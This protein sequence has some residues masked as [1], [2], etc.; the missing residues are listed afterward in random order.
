MSPRMPNPSL[1]V[2]DV[3]PPMRALVKAVN[4]VGVPLQTLV[5]IHLRVS[6]I[7]GRTVQLPTK[8]R[9]FEEA[10][11]EDHR[12]PLVEVWREQTCF[13]DAERSVLALAEAATRID[14]RPDP[15]SDEV[16]EEAARHWNQVQLAAVV[17]HIGLVNL[18]NRVNVATR[19][20]PVDWRINPK[21]W[22]PMTS[23]LTP[24]P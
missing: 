5:L 7:N 19:Q 10:G 16:W 1:V 23:R 11:E 2:P 3:L 18:W 13:T 4:S 8:Q 6:Q 20:E 14:G 12:L 22:T 15:V 21:T 24:A 9:E 17:M